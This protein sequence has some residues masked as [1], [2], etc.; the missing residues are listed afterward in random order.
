MKSSNELLYVALKSGASFPERVFNPGWGEFLFLDSDRLFMASFVEGLQSLLDVDGA[1]SID[2]INLDEIKRGIDWAQATVT[3]QRDTSTE[4]YIAM[5]QGDGPAHG[6]LFGMDS[7]AFV[8]E[9]GS[10]VIYAEKTSETAVVGF[11]Q[12]ND[13]S[14]LVYLFKDRFAARP[15]REAFTE[16]LSYVFSERGYTSDWRSRL[17]SNY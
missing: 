3:V 16:P 9:L 15:I 2:V 10:W 4:A 8:E 13:I 11:Q 14:Q 17:I 7:F 12:R 6:W 5:L 1:R